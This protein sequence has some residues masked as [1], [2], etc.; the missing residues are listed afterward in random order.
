MVAPV[1]ADYEYQFKDTGFKL[2]GASVL[3]FFDVTKVTGLSDLPEYDVKEDDIDSQDGGLIYVKYSK[4]RIITVEGILYAN[5]A[6]IETTIDTLIANFQP[7]NLDWPFHFKL[8]GVAQR[9]VSC[10]TYGF[11][12]DEE[13][14]RR[15][16]QAN[17][18]LTFGAENPHKKVDNPNLQLVT[19][20]TNYA[21]T[22]SGLVATAP[23]ITITGG[24]MS[25]INLTNQTTGKTLTLTRSF[26]TSDVTVVDMRRNVVYVNGI[27]NSAISSGSFWDIGAGVTASLRFTF[28]GSAAPTSVIVASYSG[29]M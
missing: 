23:T 12:S 5:P 11:K 27:Q 19:A 20:G 2:N 25:V 22:N 26:V 1:L 4:H 24:T 14:L 29:W 28:T 6:T 13:T 21:V 18:L 7:D 15:L 10:K 9:Y 17:C 8:P 16:G 3:P